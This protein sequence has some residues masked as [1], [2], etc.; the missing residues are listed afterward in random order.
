M[1]EYFWWPHC[2]QGNTS[3]CRFRRA[4][5]I[6]AHSTAWDCS[7]LHPSQHLL[8]ITF[9]SFANRKMM[10][11]YLLFNSCIV[12]VL[13]RV[14]LFATAWTAT[15]Q[16]PLS[17]GILQASNLE[18]VSMPSP[19]DRHDPGVEPGSPVNKAPNMSHSH[20]KHSISWGICY[21]PAHT[22]SFCSAVCL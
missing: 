1:E 3:K 17:V 2:V 9:L 12:C 19:G 5:P 18:W 11:E 10:N 13:S 6:D 14:R 22:I 16:A 4:G 7:S 8:L 20:P 21:W 15:H